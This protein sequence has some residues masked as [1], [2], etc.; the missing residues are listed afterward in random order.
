MGY[1][2]FRI[3]FVVLL[4]TGITPVHAFE[5]SMFADA[6]LNSGNDEQ[7]NFAIGQIELLAEQNLSDKTYAIVDV[8]V[9]AKS[10][11]TQTDIERLSINRMVGDHFEFGV[12][13]YIRPLGF[14]NHN[15]SHGS[16]SQHTV[17]RPF[18]LD[19]EEDHKGFLPSHLIGF[20]MRGETQSWTFQFAAANTDGV[21]STNPAIGP[22]A[23]EIFPLNSDVPNDKV[24][25]LFRTTYLATDN[26]EFGLTLGSH[27]YSE[28]STTGLVGE[29]EVLFEQAYAAM[30]FNINA[31]PVYLFGEYYFLQY[32]DNPNIASSGATPPVQA[33]PDTYDA[34]AYYVQLGVRA[35]DKLTF[36]TRY[37][38]LDFD[39]NATIFQIQNIVPQNQTIIGFNYAL[40]Q[41]NAIRF[42]VKD[43]E[44]ETG[45]TDTIYSLQWFF[46]LL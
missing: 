10:H 33:N 4:L 17:S 42:E 29:G 39:D 21:N 25:L 45:E 43:V 22:D 41:S 19:I 28:T 15:F 35:T 26:L 18:L 30:D 12:G 31:G 23:A 44:P 38:S 8:M 46:Y 24:T 27:N 13:R 2:S 3:L 36:V 9:E 34:T 7:N 32:D 40:E 16:L 1:Y 37:E 20:L 6:T 14:W 5:F 11:E